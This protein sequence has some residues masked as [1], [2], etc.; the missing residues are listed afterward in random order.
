MTTIEVLN[1]TY[2]NNRIQECKI[3]IAGKEFNATWEDPEYSVTDIKDKKDSKGREDSGSDEE[4]G[5]SVVK[6]QRVSK[7]RS[8]RNRK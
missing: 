1:I 2:E 3:I 4:E 6:E 5:R 7:I 8:L